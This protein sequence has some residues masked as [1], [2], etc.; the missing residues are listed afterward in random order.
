MSRLEIAM[1]DSV[2]MVKTD[3]GEWSVKL[4][5]GERIEVKGVAEEVS[6]GP[7]R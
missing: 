3:D 1:P 4:V 6:F 2:G 5:V 7:W